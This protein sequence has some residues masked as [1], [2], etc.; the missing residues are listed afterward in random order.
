M[1]YRVIKIS[2]RKELN[3]FIELPFKIYRNDK[4]WVAPIRSELKRILNTKIN[5]YFR[6]ASLELFSCYK[7]SIITAR[8]LL[9]VNEDYNRKSNTKTGYFGFFEAF[10]DK[11]SVKYLLTELK[12]YCIENGI[13]RL[14]G[15][16]NPNLY[17]EIGM[18]CSSYDSPPTFFQTY[19]PEYYN[20]LLKE[21]GFNVLDVLHTRMN[22]DSS[23]YLN[24]KYG[25]SS[26][27]NKDDL[28]VRCFDNRNSAR[29]LEILRDIYNDAF[30]DNWHFTNVSKEEYLFVSKHL[31]LVTSPDMIK[32]VEYKGEPVA[33]VHFALDVN[34]LLRK[35]KGKKSIIRYLNFLFE[36]K[37]IDRA[38]IFAVAIKKN[39]RNS[40][41]TDLLFR[42]TISIA[43]N[44]KIVET[45]WMHDENRVVISIAKKLGLVRDK[46]FCIY[47]CDIV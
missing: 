25:Q 39:F 31:K 32:F 38:V 21:N 7:D 40:R 43:K 47:F 28:F 4:L 33:V 22:T 36:R 3:D 42:S 12:K 8:I 46:E 10:N 27:I 2:T 13:M 11:N 45:T 19:N 14:E 23:R 26:E 20:T 34:P 18:L 29:D 5:P 24:K 30:S 44:Y 15:P 37:H 17:S 1:S 9:S 35:F 16:F 6:K 41:V